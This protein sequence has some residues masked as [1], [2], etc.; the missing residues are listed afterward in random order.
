[1]VEI[2]QSIA[3]YSF[4]FFSVAVVRLGGSSHLVYSITTIIDNSFR[5]CCET[6]GGSSHL[7]YIVLLLLL[8]SL[9]G[10]AV[11]LLVEVVIWFI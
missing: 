11:K 1:M 10:T 4:L 7:V 6:V 5:I 3:Y 8:I 9:S 2:V